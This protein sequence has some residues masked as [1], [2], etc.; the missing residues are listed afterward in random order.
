MNAKILREALLAARARLI[1][2]NKL[3]QMHSVFG[4]GTA[5]DNAA[6]DEALRKIEAALKELQA[7][8]PK[9]HSSGVKAKQPPRRRS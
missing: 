3:Q 1:A 5:V 4:R 6:D 2:Y 8:Q 9:A 7:A